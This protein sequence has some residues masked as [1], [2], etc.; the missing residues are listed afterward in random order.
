ML[1][2]DLATRFVMCGV[3][4]LILTLS[5]ERDLGGR[6]GRQQ[7]LGERHCDVLWKRLLEWNNA[8][9]EDER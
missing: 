9:I 7:I 3:D 5:G 6:Q 1:G 8:N 2:S 4:V